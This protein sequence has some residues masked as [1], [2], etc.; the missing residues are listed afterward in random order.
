LLSSF[1]AS[2]SA[3]QLTLCGVFL[4]DWVKQCAKTAEE[5]ALFANRT[6]ENGPIVAALTRL[7]ERTSPETYYESEQD[8]AAIKAELSTIC[9]LIGAA[10][11]QAQRERLVSGTAKLADI[12]HFLQVNFADSLKVSSKRAAMRQ[13]ISDR[14][15]GLDVALM[16]FEKAQT[17]LDSRV[18]TSAA[19]ALIWLR[20]TPR[21]LNPIIQNVMKGI[22]VSPI[23]EE[24][25]MWALTSHELAERT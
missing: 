17:E 21:R 22:K 3:H 6:V 8:L 20:V 5:R 14:K 1:L 19:A 25:I 18:A 7:T 16:R 23:S 12:K 2:T 10:G 24:S 9:D 13:Q 11:D 4:Q 15:S